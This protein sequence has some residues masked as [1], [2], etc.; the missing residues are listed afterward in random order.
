MIVTKFFTA[1]CNMLPDYR[2]MVSHSTEF[3]DS[4]QEESSINYKD[5][6]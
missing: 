6:A 4:S 5:A 3:I 1:F 2:V